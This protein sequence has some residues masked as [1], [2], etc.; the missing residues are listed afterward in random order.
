MRPACRLSADLVPMTIQAMTL[1][2]TPISPP[3]RSSPGLWVPCATAFIASAC[4]MIVELLAFRLVSRYLGNSN[5]TTTAI[6]GVVL[7]GLALGNYIGGRIADR[8]GSVSALATLF[9][10]AS[11]G[12]FAIPVINALIGL[13]NI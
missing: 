6:I 10:L 11:A 12:C 5:Y 1:P 3:P 2:P 8:F 13:D 7:G 9:V 4:V